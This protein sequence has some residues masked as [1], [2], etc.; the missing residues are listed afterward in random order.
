MIEYTPWL[1]SGDRLVCFGDSLTHNA[2]GYV[3]ILQQKLE[4]KGVTVINAGNGGDN[5]LTALL[6]L[7][8]DVLD[9]KPT[10][11]SVMLGTNDSQIGRGIWADEPMISPEAFRSALIWIMYICKREGIS[12][13]SITPPLW[14]F[15]G[16][17]L[18]DMGDVLPPYCQ[19]A[20]DAAAAMQ[21]RV[22]P[23]DV[24]FALEWAKHPGHNGLLLTTDGCH[25]N[26]KGNQ[27]VAEAALTAWDVGGQ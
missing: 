12:K 10:A 13:F 17:V 6:R 9:Q 24:A 21:A 8:R 25:L 14:R 2:N 7:R 5:T 26:E 1:S 3:R 23:A 16:P 20:R 27:L 19:A 4:G 18:L 22:V 11:V 15:E